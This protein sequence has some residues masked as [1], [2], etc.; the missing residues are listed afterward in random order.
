VLR[1]GPGGAL[2]SGD[3]GT[4]CDDRQA[5]IIEGGSATPAMPFESRP[6]QALGWLD[7]THVLVEAGGCANPTELYSV[8]ARGGQPVALVTG[9][10]LASP[11]TVL[12]NAPDT[13]PAPNSA[14]GQPPLGGLG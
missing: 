6:T 12:R 8:D 10:E 11:R 14:A 1:S 4:V 2:K 7:R 5:L 9:A 13:V 3:T